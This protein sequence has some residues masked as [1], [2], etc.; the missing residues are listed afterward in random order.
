M[1]RNKINEILILYVRKKR[2]YKN[3]GP[4]HKFVSPEVLVVKVGNQ[5]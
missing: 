2:V 1:L 5:A 3:L 4:S